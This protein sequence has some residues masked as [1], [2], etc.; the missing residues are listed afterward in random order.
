MLPG[1][2]PSL[3]NLDDWALSVM[4]SEADPSYK[5]VLVTLSCV[6]RM[7]KGAET[8]TTEVDDLVSLTGYTAQTVRIHLRKAESLG[9]VDWFYSRRRGRGWR[10]KSYFPL[11]FE[12][13]EAFQNL[14]S[15]HVK[16]SE[17]H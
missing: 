4:R 2:D 13:G 8:W 17:A 7:N 9:L 11:A 6:V 15:S 10:K 16:H 14:T 1:N 12:T 3:M 5:H